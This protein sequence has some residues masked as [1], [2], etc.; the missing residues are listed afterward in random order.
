MYTVHE[1]IRKMYGVEV[2][3]IT[4]YSDHSTQYN[5]DEVFT[6]LALEF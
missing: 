5:N 6:T 3:D 4:G 2:K 1:T